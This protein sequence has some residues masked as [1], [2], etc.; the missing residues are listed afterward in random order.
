M[1]KKI[2]TPIAV[3]LGMVFNTGNYTAQAQSTPAD[4]VSYL[5]AEKA[6]VKKVADNY[7][8]VP[9]SNPSMRY[10][11][12]TL[13][14]HLKIE[15]TEVIVT[16]IVRRPPPNVRTL[17]HPLDIQKVVAAT[18][19]N[20]NT[21]PPP[22]KNNTPPTTTD[23]KNEKLNTNTP[24]TEIPNTNEPPQILDFNQT[25]EGKTQLKHHENGAWYVQLN[26]K[27]YEIDTNDPNFTA[28]FQKE[29]VKVN[30][31]AQAAELPLPM[32]RIS[33]YIL[34][35]ETITLAPQKKWWQFWVTE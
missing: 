35:I 3:L 20:N 24:A 34:K 9:H 19:K 27:Q 1:I 32:Q 16:G 33:P 17:A 22:K 12:N 11:A 18:D 15:G 25:I 23:P 26:N 29:N 14:Q 21:P 28:N 4:S 30:I 10:I 7:V 2:I 8:L 5:K 31:K 13:P 6:T